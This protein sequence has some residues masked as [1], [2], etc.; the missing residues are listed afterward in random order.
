MEFNGTS[1]IQNKDMAVQPVLYFTVLYC[2][3]HVYPAVEEPVLLD[4]DEALHLPAELV[5]RLAGH[6]PRSV[7]L[8]RRGPPVNLDIL[9]GRQGRCYSLHYKVNVMRNLSSLNI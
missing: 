2:T 9:P 7:E 4:G 3:D 6:H 1:K 8:R 5:R